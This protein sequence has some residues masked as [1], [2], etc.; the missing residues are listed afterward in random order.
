MLHVVG[1]GVAEQA[2]LSVTAQ[3]AISN[4]AVVIGAARQLETVAHYVAGE[5][6]THELP[7]LQQLPELLAQYDGQDVCLL[8]SGDPLYYGIG[9]WLLQRYTRNQ[10]T[11]YPAVSSIQAACHALGLALQDVQVVSLHG[12]PLATLRRHLARNSTIL[13][14]TDAHSSPQAIARLCCT[15]GFFE[16]RLW[17]CERLGYETQ[18]V[19][20]FSVAALAGISRLTAAEIVPPEF[21]PLHVSVLE[22]RGVGGYLPAGPGIADADFITDATAGSG[23][24]TKREVRMAILGFLPAKPDSVCWDIGAGCGGVAVE[25][26][27][28]QARAQVYAIE[29]HAER[30][31]CLQQNRERFGVVDNLRVIA[32]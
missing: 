25:W 9:R 18:Q 30:L 8:A 4:S 11:F 10:L 14:L 22:V 6:P 12:R 21:D 3:Q 2:E 20:E 7:P 29:H 5:I 27:L 23:L 32:G 28:L 31:E 1:L 26:A 13:C 19:R 16:S 24:L 17:V 15:A